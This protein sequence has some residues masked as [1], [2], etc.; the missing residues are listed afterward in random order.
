MRKRSATLLRLLEVSR[1]DYSPG[2][3]ARKRGWLRALGRARL[4]TP[5]AVLRFHEHL[6]FLRAYPDDARVLAAAEGLLK[7]FAARSDLRRHRA[8]LAGSGIAG[9]DLPDRFFW[10]MARWLA[11]RWPAQLEIDWDSVDDEGALAAALPLLVTPA[12]A[13]WLRVLKPGARA[14]IERL[15]GRAAGGTFYVRRVAAMPGDDFTREAFFDRIDLDL[16]LRSAPGTP[17]RT[18]ARRR[19]AQVAFRRAAPA[20]ARP[21]LRAQLAIAPREVRVA[22]AREARGLID[23]ARETLVTRG[24]DLD[25]FAYGNTADVRVV[26]DGNGLQWAVIGMAPERRAPL[27]AAYGYLML[28]NGV[29]VGY[30]QID[31]LFACTDLA[32]NAFPA[33]RGGEAAFLFARLL[34][35]AKA[36]FGAR[37]FTLEPYQLGHE[38][39]E[40]IESGAWWFYYKLGFRPRK[41]R[42][43]ALAQG[44][45]AR[46]RRNPAYRS[47]ERILERLAA[48]YLYFEPEGRRAPHWPSIAALGAQVAAHLAALAG[49]DREAGVEACVERA[50]QRV[51]AR[52][53]ESAGERI[54][55]RHWAPVI[56]LVPGI[57]RW[58]RA[59]RRALAEVVAAKGGKRETEYLLRF[60]AHPKLGGVVRKLAGA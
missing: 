21:D 31:T 39:H 38:N 46:M 20:R 35:M 13:N 29:P 55:W 26:D 49:A 27:R 37:S 30:G 3:A 7:A 36:V 4:A 45:L 6:C 56:D 47:P 22:P 5:A 17:S 10:P 32:F 25:A 15:R 33:F 42:I 34:A 41:H 28:R 24:R 58:T 57:A 51:G 16:V 23:L 8:A 1:D 53:P 2:A 14:A 12:E 52:A 44:E 9:T 43:A 40:G 50:R 18:L 60:D 19:G 48:D 59:E 11:L 54:A